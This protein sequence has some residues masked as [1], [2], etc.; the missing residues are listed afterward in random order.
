MNFVLYTYSIYFRCYLN[1]KT[2]FLHKS[3]EKLKDTIMDTKADVEIGKH[4][5]KLMENLVAW[6]YQ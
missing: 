1:N 3:L 5:N 4:W 2:K 6:N